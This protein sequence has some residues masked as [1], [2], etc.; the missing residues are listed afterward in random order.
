M[1]PLAILTVAIALVVILTMRL[2]LDAFIAL[3]AAATLVGVLAPNIPLDQVMLRVAESFGTVAG[4]IGIVIALAAVVGE[5]L[6][7]S[8]AA[9][10][11]T[12]VFVR[13]FGEKRASLS[14]PHARRGH[15]RIAR[16]PCPTCCPGPHQGR[17]GQRKL[18]QAGR[19]ERALVH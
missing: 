12:R 6:L 8:G 11:T 10:K 19:Q 13:L 18:P 5:C 16:R 1:Q 15:P 14:L 7:E 4:K 17:G 3:I 2:R 9:D